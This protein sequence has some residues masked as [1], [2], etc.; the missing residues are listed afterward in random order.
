[1][2]IKH[3]QSGFSLLILLLALMG[4]GGFALA[5][6]SQNLNK[7]VEKSRYEHN[8]EVLRKAKDAL[9]MYAYRYPQISF[10]SGGTARGPGRLPCPDTDNN[11]KPNPSF[12]CKSGSAIVG[13]FPWEAPGMDF[14]KAKDVSGEL[15]WYAVSKNFANLISPAT[16]DVINSDR[17]GTITLFDQTGKLIYDGSVAGIAAVI[18]AP[19]PAING[20]NRSITNG[21]D[22]GDDT[23]DSDPGI[24]DPANYLDA[25]SGFDNSSFVNSSS[26]VSA[27][28]FILGPVFDP[29]QNTY[30]INDQMIIIT[31][32]EVI[33]M[34]E[35]VVLKAYQ[36]AIAN[37]QQQVW[38]VT[39]ANYRYPWLN[40]YAEMND[41]LMVYNP[42]AGNNIGRIPITPSFA[43]YDSVTLETDMAVDYQVDVSVNVTA[44]GYLAGVFSVNNHS[45]TLM[46]T[47]SHL[48]FSK[49]SFDG[50]ADTKTDNIGRLEISNGTVNSGNVI[51]SPAKYFWDG[52]SSSG[53][54]ESADGWE[55]CNGSASSPMD[56]ARSSG[57]FVP[58]VGWGSH[59]DIKIRLVQ[60]RW[61]IDNQF[62]LGL[63][64]SFLPILNILTPPDAT[65]H[66][67]IQA[68]LPLGTLLT[69]WKHL[70]ANTPQDFIDGVE[71]YYEQDNLVG[72]TFNVPSLGN[73][74]SGSESGIL[75][76]VSYGTAT[77]NNDTLAITYDYHIQVPQWVIENNWDSSVMMAYSSAYSPA[78]I[79]SPP[80][81][82]VANNGDIVIDPSECI[83]LN[84]FLANTNKIKALL[85]LGG[86]G[87]LVD[88]A[89]DNYANDLV[90][91]FDGDNASVTDLVFDKR[92][93]IT[94]G[95]SKDKILIL[96]SL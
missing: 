31:A 83:Q 17:T 52:C 85:V 92:A 55:I 80:P 5:N 2:C 23:A 24:I 94:P 73:A 29:V 12:N 77:V 3:N 28:G 96:E 11:G 47:D 67:R 87:D 57:A 1:M 6:Y 39:V 21:D 37:Y 34:A 69:D 38:G 78:V 75:A 40:T 91:I 66:A 45:A 53:C 51:S 32:E 62:R 42:S 22:P 56:C 54:F 82:C 30:V 35:K 15:L 18:I 8:K 68:A 64:H 58:F 43:D 95:N 71:F 25:F 88:E 46:T 59:D 81:D 13:R 60:A 49:M 9:L 33:A 19:G 44:P 65:N 26:A 72:S 90:D 63:D 61:T 79:T 74:D 10:L 16:N 4:L 48:A 84:S 14:Y 70:T 20:Q 89:G 27:D 41:P 93:S 50:S 36:D 86:E 76:G 7:Q